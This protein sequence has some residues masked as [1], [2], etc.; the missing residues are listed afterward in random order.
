MSASARIRDLVIR[1]GAIA[2]GSCDQ[3]VDLTGKFIVP[4][5]VDHH[6]HLFLHA[7]DSNGNIRPR[8]DRESALQMLQLFLRFGVTSI[9]DPGAETEAAVELRDLVAAHKL[10]GPNIVSA[11]RIINDG[12]LDAEPFVQLRRADDIRREIRW[13]KTAGVDLIKVYAATPPD[14]VKVAIDEAHAQH[15]PI[16]GHMQRTSW[17]Q[18]AEMGIDGVEHPADWNEDML[19]PDKRAAYDN[20]MFGRVYWIENL[21]PAA[22]DRTIA[23][24][25]AHHVSVDPTLM[26]IATKFFGNSPRW[27][28]NPDNKRMP[29]IWLEGWP[30]GSF[31]KTWTPAQFAE[32]QS[33]W[34]K[35]L[36]FVKKMYDAGVP[37]VAGTDT[38][39]P[40]IVPGASMHDEMELLH[41]A[42]IPTMAVLKMACDRLD[43]NDRADLVVLNANPLGDIRNTRRIA[44]VYKDGVPVQ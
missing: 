3:R 13:Q 27:L 43:V 30:A 38:P 40:W 34:P 2:T 39:T 28:H 23:A 17:L 33:A 9:R 15:L 36:A 42:G 10:K 29:Q 24:L 4:G 6:A 12:Q 19:P 41:D 7:W 44:A 8:W 20:S 21:D 1:N 25:K 16:I 31:V 22:V 26:A 11:G 32:A 5:F 35:L 37:M 18:A 14:L